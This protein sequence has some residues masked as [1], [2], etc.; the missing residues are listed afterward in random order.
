[1]FN[2]PNPDNRPIDPKEKDKRRFS[3]LVIFIVIIGLSAV[4]FILKMR[5]ARNSLSEVI[6]TREKTLVKEKETSIVQKRIPQNSFKKPVPELKR[7]A[8][9]VK[10]LPVSKRGKN[11]HSFKLKR[12]LKYA[13]EYELVKGVSYVDLENVIAV[14]PRERDRFEKEDIITEKN[15][16]LFVFVEGNAIPEGS[17]RVVHNIRT[18][19]LGLLTGTLLLKFSSIEDFE[20]RVQFIRENFK[21]KRTF[22]AIKLSLIESLTPLTLSDLQKEKSYWQGVQGLKSVEIEIIEDDRRSN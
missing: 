2:D 19:K 12:P 10:V 3:L 21:E 17:L 13:G 7:L 8:P 11:P 20:E 9:S 18:K 16:H 4:V 22:P 6:Q 5:Q 1:M 15:N 14:N